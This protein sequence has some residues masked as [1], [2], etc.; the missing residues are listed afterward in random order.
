MK[1]MRKTLSLLVA[2]VF[3][4]SQCL[5]GVAFADTH[6]TSTTGS[7]T[8]AEL[9]SLLTKTFN[10]PS[11][12]YQKFS[13]VSSKD[14]YKSVVGKV[15]LAGIMST[16]SKYFKPNKTMSR[17]TGAAI[18]YKAFRQTVPKISKPTGK[19]TRIEALKLIDKLTG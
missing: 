15:T 9:A 5:S 6:S 1:K 14:W 4:F 8:K 12:T 18:I 7:I 17:K 11:G 13:D 10:L 3:L 16:K 19:L 2:L